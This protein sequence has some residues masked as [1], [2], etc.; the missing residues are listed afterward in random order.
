M[1][2]IMGIIQFSV[3][4]KGKFYIFTFVLNVTTIEPPALT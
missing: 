3:M 1:K 2:S 4:L